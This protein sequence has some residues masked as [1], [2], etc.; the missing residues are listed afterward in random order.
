MRK[1]FLLI[2]LTFVVSLCFAVGMTGC[3]GSSASQETEKLKKEL[4][5]MKKQAEDEKLAKQKDDLAKQQDDLKKE[6]KK[7]A[8]DKKNS[9]QPV[10]AGPVFVQGELVNISIKSSFL[11]LRSAPN[12]T[13]EVLAEGLNGDEVEIVSYDRT[14]CKVLFKGKEGYMATRF[15]VKHRD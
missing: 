4:D 10:K 14:W 2:T 9:A 13:S 6:Q 1:N 5:D 11:K 7:L 8:D 12:E 15:L 3:S